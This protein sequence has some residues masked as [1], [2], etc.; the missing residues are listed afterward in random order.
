MGFSTKVGE[1]EAGRPDSACCVRRRPRGKEVAWERAQARAM[2]SF[3]PQVQKAKK[4]LAAMA[5]GLVEGED[6]GAQSASP[7]Q[8]QLQFGIELARQGGQIKE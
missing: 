7:A 4:P 2:K 6:K 1:A 5:N 3:L 8:A